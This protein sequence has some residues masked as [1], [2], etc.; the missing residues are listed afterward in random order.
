MVT[1]C[2]PEVMGQRSGLLYTSTGYKQFLFLKRHTGSRI[3]AVELLWFLNFKIFPV[4]FGEG[5]Y[6]LPIAARVQPQPSEV[7]DMNRHNS[8]LEQT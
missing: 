8:T 4:Q 7:P 2:Q 1:L 5:K 3:S 6:I